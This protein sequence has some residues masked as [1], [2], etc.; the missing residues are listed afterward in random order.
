MGFAQLGDGAQLIGVIESGDAG[1]QVVGSI[2]QGV[3][4]LQ[5]LAPWAE[6]GLTANAP[7]ADLQMCLFESRL[8]IGR[9]TVVSGLHG[10]SERL[11]STFGESFFAW[12]M[13]D[14]VQFP[15]GLFIFGA[16]DQHGS[17]FEVKER[18]QRRGL[19]CLLQQFQGGVPLMEVGGSQRDS[20]VTGCGG[21]RQG[22]GLTLL[23]LE[24]I[25][26]GS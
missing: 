24:S 6:N 7:A 17:A 12:S 20:D 5:A 16:H 18:F 4:G 8:L 3:D 9:K 14:D 22:G 25:Y 26:R 2:L 15:A 10:L 1:C 13:G 11:V 21:M 23:T 19:G